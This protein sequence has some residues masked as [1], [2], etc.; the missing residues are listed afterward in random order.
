MRE[1][2]RDIG[3]VGQAVG[4]AHHHGGTLFE[5]AEEA[6]FLAAMG[7]LLKLRLLRRFGNS[8]AMSWLVNLGTFGL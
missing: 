4:K 2:L 3:L 7:V 5:E 1:Y 6:R 8:P